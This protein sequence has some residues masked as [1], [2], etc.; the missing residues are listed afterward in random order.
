MALENKL[1]DVVESLD[2]DFNEFELISLYPAYR[3]AQ[4]PR[5][6]PRPTAIG[7]WLICC[8]DSC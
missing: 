6:H 3:A 5:D 1:K 8:M 2:Y 7:A 4:A